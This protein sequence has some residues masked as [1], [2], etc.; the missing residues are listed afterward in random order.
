MSIV[1]RVLSLFP[2]PSEVPESAQL[3]PLHQTESLIDGRLERWSG[4]VD[5]VVSP[6]CFREG[7]AL[8]PVTIGSYP[9]MTRTEALRA[10]DAAARAYDNGQG[11]W[12]TMPLTERIRCL[13]RFVMGMKARRG[14]VVRFLMWEIGKS[15][16]ASEQEFD[17]TVE[18]IVDTIDAAKDMDRAS[19]RFQIEQGVV[20]QIRRA[21]LGVTLCMGPFNYPLNETFTLLIPALLMGNTTIFKP[22]RL[23]VLLHQPFLE[24]YRDAFPP[25][26]VNTV[27]G[28]GSEVISPLMESGQVHVLAFIGSCRVSNIIRRQHPLPNQLRCVLGLEA[29]N[30]GIVLPC[31]DLDLAVRESLLGS[32]SYNG[33]RC[34]ALKALWVHRSLADEFV[35]Q[36][37]RA[38]ESLKPG[39]PWESDVDLTP[40][41]EPGKTEWLTELVKDAVDKGARVTNAHGGLTHGTFFYPAILYPVTIDST[42]ARVEQ[43]GPVVPVIP[44]DD[45]EEPLRWIRESEYGQQVSLFGRNP[46]QLAKLIDPLVNQVCRVNLNSQCQR[47][48]DTFPFTGR[49][50]SAEHTLSVSDALR[51]FSI[52]TLVAAKNTEENQ[53]II[54]TMLRERSSK[55]LSTDFIL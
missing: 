26:V 24:I 34:T 11:V 2:S 48:P 13:Q 22:P 29:K 51:V 25:G 5:E 49:K 6:I 30:A 47:G 12:P 50:N 16:K 32:L 39:M 21:P 45:L 15:R 40:L 37:S 14:T 35:T 20:G 36:L 7:D 3:E 1:E 46:E 55:F 23:G 27:Y 33:Q 19:S 8:V 28:D 17:R 9:R 18:Y 42:V 54:T 41:P 38:V 53:D 31:A 10:L 4:P 44:F 52:R 43:F